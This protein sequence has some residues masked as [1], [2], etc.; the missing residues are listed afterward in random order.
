MARIDARGR[1][2][3]LHEHGPRALERVRP[4]SARSTFAL[5]RARLWPG[6]RVLT[7]ATGLAAA[8]PVLVATANAV[9]G[10]WIP[11]ADQAIIATRA[12]DVFSSH[13]PLVG[14]YT[15]V[16]LVTGKVTHGLGPMLF[17][18]LALPA[19]FGGTASIT[20]MM[21]IVNALTIVGVVA[22]ARRRGGVVLMFAAAL[23]VALMCQS[24]AAETFHDVWNPSAG[25]F[26]FTLLIF[27]CWSLACGEYRLLPLTVVVASFVVQAH[28][29]YLP[30]TAGLLA[31]GVGGLVLW[32]MAGRRGHAGGRPPASQVKAS[33][34]LAEGAPAGELP[35]AGTRPGRRALSAWVGAAAVVAAICWSAPVVDELV[36]RSGNASLVVQAAS[37]SKP[38]LGASVGWN[39]VVRAVGA[40]PWW[41]YVPANRWERKYDVRTTP[42]RGAVD[43]CIAL[44]AALLLAMLVGLARRRRD[45]VA[46]ALIGFVLCGSLAVVAAFTPTPRVLSATLGYTM[47]WGSQVGMWVWLMLAWFVL[48][49]LAWALSVLVALGAAWSSA[50]SAS[51]ARRLGASLSRVPAF[52]LLLAPVLACIVGM[53][54][55]VVVASSVAAT[56]RRDEHATLYRATAALVARL[57]RA[58]PSGRTVKLVGSLGIATLPIR[59]ALRY[60]LVRHGVR[61][62]ARGSELRL[63]DWYELY[64]RPYQYV[65]Y[66]EDGVKPPAKRARLVDRVGFRDGWGAQIVS[67]WVSRHARSQVRGSARSRT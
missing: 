35:L 56:E 16:G 50:R 22:L 48:L 53:T 46:G 2:S 36:E 66:V 37:A 9:R 20:W 1:A 17:W 28:L 19:R 34:A 54:A 12:H 41:L 23:A 60:F 57:D 52:V 51:E 18:L 44:L 39:A 45:V 29:M 65:V 10:G 61:P 49:G 42:R 62:L 32:L 63:G 33:Q 58:I 14:Q 38:V 59:P 24:L 43:S 27:L 3:W 31:V 6:R 30:A 15:L 55:I 8:I 26:P 7:L 5:A 4:Q 21:G 64:N 40:R 25:L 67:L 13:T 47:W 11:G